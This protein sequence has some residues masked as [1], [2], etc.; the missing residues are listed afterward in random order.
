M[1]PEVSLPLPQRVLL[2]QVFQF[3]R[4]FAFVALDNEAPAF[5]KISYAAG[6][7]LSNS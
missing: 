5:L 1:L 3:Q 6:R 4:V 2:I 7:D